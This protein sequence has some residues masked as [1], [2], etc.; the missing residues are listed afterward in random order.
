MNWVAGVAVAGAVCHRDR[1]SSIGHRR[2]RLQ[3]AP[4]PSA[5]GLLSG[6]LVRTVDRLRSAPLIPSVISVF[7][8]VLRVPFLGIT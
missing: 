3:T 2:S 8:R 5:R 6:W 1:R 4:T 7:L